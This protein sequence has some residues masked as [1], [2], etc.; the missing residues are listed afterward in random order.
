[1][2]YIIKQPILINDLM[3]LYESV[4]WI[5][6]TNDVSSMSQLLTNSLWW[7]ACYEKNELVGLVRVVGDGLAVVL[8][9]D[10]LVHPKKWRQG[11]GSQLMKVTL[12]H[13]KEIRQLMVITENKTETRMFY[14]SCGLKL[15]ESYQCLAFARFQ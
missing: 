4:K 15:L 11:I 13:F 10:L 9:Q 5:S 2:E 1:M 3:K 6:Y 8:V 14:E 7:C 12:H